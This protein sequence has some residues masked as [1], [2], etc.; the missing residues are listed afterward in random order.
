M[1][2][3]AAYCS[4]VEV[5]LLGPLEV[6]G[7]AGVIG[8][9]SAKP[10]GV[11]AFLALR[12]GRSVSVGE[13]IAGLWGQ[14]PPRSA[15][16]LV[17]VYVSRLR[18]VLPAGTITTSPGGY[19]LAVA[20]G[21]VDAGRFEEMVRRGR[22]AFQAGSLEEAAAALGEGLSLWRGRPLVEVSDQPAGRA[23]AVRLQELRRSAEE[24]LVE[25]RLALGQHQEVVADLEMA[26]QA[27]P[28]RERR[29]AQLMLA[30]YRSG[31][32]GEAL[33]A[34][35]R[36][37]QLLVEELGI[38]PSQQVRRLET[39]ILNQAPWL[40]AGPG[41]QPGDVAPLER[42]AGRS[43]V[44]G[45]PDTS[46]PGGQRGLPVALAAA[47]RRGL[48]GRDRELEGL[49]QAVSGDPG[50][51]GMVMVVGEP[52]VGKTRMAAAAAQSVLDAGGR[53]LF[54]RCD[55][56]L[57]AGYQPFVEALSVYIDGA[58]TEELVA[59]LGSSGPELARLVPR[60]AERVPALGEPRAGVAEAE[61]WYLFQ[62]VASFLRSVSGGGP[63]VMVIDDLQ[64]AEPATLLML[65]HLAR[66]SIDGLVMVATARTPATGPGGP[67][68]EAMADLAG[69]H[70]LATV[71][72]EGLSPAGTEA[73]VAGR[74]HRAPGAEFVAALH[75]QTAGNPFFVHE[76]LTHLSDT[77]ALDEGPAPWPSAAQVEQCGAS[78]G[79]RQ[80]LF[81]RVQQLS[82]ATAD[83]ITVA[84][85]AG[86]DFQ[87]GQ[88][89]QLLGANPGELTARLDEAAASGLVAESG[90]GAGGYRFVH[91]LV[92][93]TLY[94]SLSRL[95]RAQLHWRLAEAL[96]TSADLET[97]PLS[98]MAYHYRLGVDAGDAVV[99][100]EYVH[101]AADEA[102]SQLAF[103]QAGQLY[104]AALAISEGC[105]QNP[106]HRY[107]LLAGCGQSASAM[108]DFAASHEAWL[109]A[110]G[111][112][113]S[114]GDLTRFARAVQGWAAI[115]T[116]GTEDDTILRLCD[117]GLRLA[118]PGDSAERAR[119]LAWRAA[120]D[121]TN[122]H[123]QQPTVREALAMARRIGDP[124]AEK[125]ALGSLLGTLRGTSRGQE[126]LEI[127]EQLARTER[128]LGTETAPWHSDR[129]VALAC[130]QVGRRGQAE[131][132]LEQAEEAARAGHRRLGLHNVL[133][134]KAAIMNAKG[135][136]A[137]AKQLA[138]QARDLGDPSN[139]I[140]AL[141]YAAQIAA[142][143]VEQGRGD[144]ILDQWT[145]P[146]EQLL[147]GTAT[148]RTMLA[149][150]RA[151]LGRLDEAAQRLGAL[152]VD[153]FAVIPRDWAFPLA[154]RYLPEIC[155]QLGDRQTAAQLLPDIEPYRGQLLV[156]S[157]GAT[158]EGAAD[159]SLGQ[160]YGLL[161][162]FDDAN[163]SFE[164]AARLEEDMGFVAHVAR[165]RYWH[166]R[167]LAQ[168]G[169]ARDRRRGLELLRATQSTTSTLG[170]SLLN[171]QANIL[172]R[173]VHERTPPGG[174]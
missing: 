152:A 83:A 25:V 173:L 56:G 94:E 144:Q 23:E 51:V 69:R 88:L 134:I 2:G 27:E 37:S 61:R 107:D 39:D 34:F 24:D 133:M 138:R 157:L 129:D 163:Q 20:P 95:R 137:R 87:A 105:P 106:I 19:G 5:K 114:A 120:H 170:M 80:V 38:G 172:Y 98:R 169:K 82:A 54:G 35:T 110:A 30:L 150:L 32:Q 70:L 93:H 128:H 122:P 50:R 45:T 68:A 11:L 81:N 75:A 126:M 113:E 53:V 121:H 17:Q 67:L 78:A 62:A 21:Q 112:A 48:V 44:A 100:L 55:E 125:T 108:A 59:Q 141:G 160:L 84:S 101:R 117:R 15:E 73:L 131:S 6:T 13:L 22:A 174:D 154:V 71:L 111:I 47:A 92:Q 86:V 146:V 89:A 156:V 1:R 28:L 139:M 104:Q 9:P 43:P 49:Q 76:L 77:G 151:D 119:F 79:I 127:S 162:R 26:V 147:P 149:A 72:L 103:E 140:V 118:G 96:R 63:V 57:G 58:S 142:S 145:A 91:A 3:G 31:R 85:V 115:S 65:R 29:W 66:A 171:H 116:V 40:Q 42:R 90:P 4:G 97:S 74:L 130:I 124:L 16:K 167:L 164:S 52:G 60:L 161:G 143:R 109:Q 166:A 135:N 159:R 46:A 10:R 155:A 36:M 8:L 7:P 41:P 168:S 12:P 14:D 136:F 33:R 148:W 165:T 99:A 153:N 158:I 123:E 102:L 132:A 64:W 18:R